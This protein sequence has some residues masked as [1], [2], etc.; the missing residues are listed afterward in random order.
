MYELNN[1][2]LEKEELKNSNASKE[3]IDRINNI[4]KLGK[5]DYIDRN[6][7]NGLVEII[8][9]TEDRGIEVIFKY[10]NLYEDA[11]RYLK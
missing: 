2:L 4:K 9:V 7:L 3:N 8:Y 11:M 10:K 1:I 5:L 6:I